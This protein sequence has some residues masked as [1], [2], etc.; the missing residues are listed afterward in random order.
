[1]TNIMG[2]STAKYCGYANEDDPEVRAPLNPSS[3]VIWSSRFAVKM[4]VPSL[5]KAAALHSWA[6]SQGL[7]QALNKGELAD[8]NRTDFLSS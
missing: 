3:F 6:A 5:F 1:M 7:I 4:L 2:K 8:F